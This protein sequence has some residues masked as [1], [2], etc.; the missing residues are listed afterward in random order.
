[1]PLI[2]YPGAWRVWWSGWDIAVFRWTLAKLSG[3]VFWDPLDLGLYHL[4]LWLVLPTPDRPQ[5]CNLRFFLDSWLL[6]EDRWQFTEMWSTSEV[7]NLSWLAAWKEKEGQAP[8]HAHT[9]IQAGSHACTTNGAASKC[10]HEHM[11]NAC[12]DTSACNPHGNASAC[13]TLASMLMATFAV[14]LVPTQP[15]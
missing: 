13:A 6:L 4:W 3:I 15:L 8:V 14:M 5:V 2:S 9:H 1:M 7:P 12:S 11:H 10:G